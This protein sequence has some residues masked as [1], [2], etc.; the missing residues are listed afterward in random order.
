MLQAHGPLE[1]FGLAGGLEQLEQ[2]PDHA[3]VVFGEPV[4][5]SLAPRLAPQEHLPAVVPQVVPH[6]RGRTRREHRVVRAGVAPVRRQVS[7]E[8]PRGPRAGRDHE[9]VPGGDD[10]VV[11]VGTR[12]TGA[13]LQEVP[14]SSHDRVHHVDWRPAHLLRDILDGPGHVEDVLRPEFALRIV[15]GVAARLDAIEEADHLRVAF[16]EAID[17]LRA[18][19][20]E[21][22]FHLP[23]LGVTTDLRW[24]TVGI[25]GG[26]ERPVGM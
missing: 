23:G 19:Q 6:E 22:P 10:L 8:H 14:A 13:R 24:H 1:P 17:L 16:Q 26:V 3:R 7:V 21:R 20:V 4:D 11:E 5:G 9:P 12:A 25:L 18:P 15:R 2:A